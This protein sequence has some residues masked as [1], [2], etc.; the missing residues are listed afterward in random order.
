M[1]SILARL[2][3]KIDFVS[4]QGL[5]ARRVIRPLKAT[6]NNSRNCTKTRSDYGRGG[7]YAFARLATRQ[8]RGNLPVKSV[9]PHVNLSAKVFWCL[10]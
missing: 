3:T 6:F 1:E 2:R 10:T 9:V 5:G 8:E 4:Q 7:G